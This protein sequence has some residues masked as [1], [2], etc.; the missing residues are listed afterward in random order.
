MNQELRI[1]NQ[2]LGMVNRE[3]RIMNQ[4]LGM[5]NRELGIMNDESGMGLWIPL[6]KE[7]IIHGRAFLNCCYI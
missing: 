7:Q 5:V 1:M 6:T 4:E 3:L 2:E